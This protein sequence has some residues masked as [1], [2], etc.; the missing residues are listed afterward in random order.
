M[1]TLQPVCDVV[2]AQTVCCSWQS[3]SND[4]HLS[5]DISLLI[6]LAF[7]ISEHNLAL[8]E[9]PHI[10]TVSDSALLVQLIKKSSQT[11]A[12]PNLYD[13]LFS[14]KHRKYI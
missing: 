8:G 13:F 9:S 5:D 11:H 6:C 3:V 14:M 7:S 1:T 4:P 2:V 10:R 12:I